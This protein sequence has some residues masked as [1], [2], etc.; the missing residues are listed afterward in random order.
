M[1]R[2]FNEQGFE[3][4]VFVQASFTEFKSEFEDYSLTASMASN[5]TTSSYCR[6]EARKVQAQY[7]RYIESLIHAKL[8]PDNAYEL[9]LI[10]NLQSD[11]VPELAY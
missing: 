9:G 4:P 1:N 10:P 8:L 2:V 7:Q 6:G 3:L 5:P 11:R